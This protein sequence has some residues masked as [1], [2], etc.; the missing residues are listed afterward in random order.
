MNKH[1]GNMFESITSLK[2]PKAIGPYS[3]AV[4]LGDFVYLSGQLPVDPSTNELI[5]GGIMEQTYQVFSNIEAVL[6]EMGLELRHILKTTVFLADLNDFE[7]MNQIYATIMSA[8]YPA[9]STI[10]VAALPK[11]AQIEI[12]CVVIDTLE[13]EKQIKEHH[14]HQHDH[15]GHDHHHGEDH[16]C[17]CKDEHGHHHHGE[18]HECQCKDNNHHEHHHGE[19]HECQCKDEH[20]HHHHG[21][22]HEC[23]C[24]DNNYHE[25]HHDAESQIEQDDTIHESNDCENNCCG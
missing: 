2:A 8:P 1:G 7:G 24:K 11:N 6:S 21:E 15:Q 4:K 19:D 14:H 23:Q 25:H 10:Q 9:R 13:Y 20:G 22:D 18:D 16:E 3:Q 17:Q 5:E 12:E